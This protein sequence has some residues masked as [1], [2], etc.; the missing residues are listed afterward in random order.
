MFWLDMRTGPSSQRSLRNFLG[1]WKGEMASSPL[2]QSFC[3]LFLALPS[4]TFQPPPWS[5][6]PIW[7]QKNFPKSYWTL[8]PRTKF[9][10]FTL[11]FGGSSG[12]GPYIL[13]RAH[14]HS[15]MSH[16]PTLHSELLL[17]TWGV[18]RESF[19]GRG[20][21]YNQKVGDVEACVGL[22]EPRMFPRE[23]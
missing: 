12:S 6:G 15:S 22:Q 21:C 9:K 3:T 8:S 19:A 13:L 7:P 23:E 5:P 18:R 17:F 1:V 11:I 20:S 2:P 16:F 10:L 14:L 4:R